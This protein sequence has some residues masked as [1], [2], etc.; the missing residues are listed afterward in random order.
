VTSTNGTTRSN[1]TTVSGPTPRPNW[2]P[3][4]AGVNPLKTTNARSATS[5]A[6]IASA[7]R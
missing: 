4:V 3:S 6:M 7:L 2:T 1:A 5:I